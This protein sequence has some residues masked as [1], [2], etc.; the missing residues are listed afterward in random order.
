MLI[1][2]SK[3]WSQLSEIDNNGEK[4]NYCNGRRISQIFVYFAGIVLWQSFDFTF[5]S[6]KNHNDFPKQIIMNYQ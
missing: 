6:T 5:H 2:F 1:M 3:G 4:C